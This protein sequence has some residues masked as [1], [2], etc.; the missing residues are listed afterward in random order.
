MLT[1][2]PASVAGRFYP[3]DA[4]ALRKEVDRLLAAVTVPEEEPTPKALIVPH[5][6]YAYSGPV[7]ACAYARLIRGGGDLKRVILLGPSHH[8]AFQGLALPEADAFETLLGTVAVDTAMLARI[9]QVRRSEAIHGSEHALEVQLPFIQRVAPEAK[10]VPLLVGQAPPRQ[11]ADVLETLWGGP[12]T[13][14]VVSSD[15]SHYLPDRLGR[16]MDRET[17]RRIL[18]LDTALEAERACGA[19]PLSGFLEA[20]RRRGLHP[21]LLDLRN[22]GDATGDLEEVV[23]YG[24][25]AFFET[26]HS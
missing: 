18:H 21:V 14:I 5:A 16:A 25:F 3:G 15:L 26:G 12:E 23:G 6:G 17:V 9:P 24:A 22:S 11:V 10:L 19:V 1:V 20:A 2:R 4:T 8:A 13:V 7:A